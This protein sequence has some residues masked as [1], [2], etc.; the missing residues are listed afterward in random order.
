M[1]TAAS[2]NGEGSN[3]IPRQEKHFKRS[4]AE[5][6]A[7]QRLTARSCQRAC[8][9]TRGHA[10]TRTPT[11]LAGNSTSRGEHSANAKRAEQRAA[12]EISRHSKKP[13]AKGPNA[14]HGKHAP[15][16]AKMRNDRRRGCKQLNETEAVRSVARAT[17]HTK[18][19]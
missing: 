16:P 11:A 13:K 7:R 12:R 19:N 3:G 1:R 10:R 15:D 4:G 18:K 9:H 2:V 6:P 17:N 14:S 5:A 8:S